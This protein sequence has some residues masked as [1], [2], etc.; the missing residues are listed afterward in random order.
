MTDREIVA[1]ITAAVHDPYR[2]LWLEQDDRAWQPVRR[3]LAHAVTAHSKA[4]DDLAADGPQSEYRRR[5]ARDVLKPLSLAL[6]RSELA[7]QLHDRLASTA[8]EVRTA[9]TDLPELVRAPVTPTALHGRAGLGAGSQ[10]KRIFARALRPVVWR[11]AEHDIAVSSVARVHLESEVIPAQARAFNASQRARAAWLGQL[12]RAW[13]SWMGGAAQMADAAGRLQSELQALLDGIAEASGRAEGDD[14]DRLAER[15]EATVAIAGTFVAND[16]GGVPGAWSGTQPARLWDEWAEQTA[17][18]LE[19]YHRLLGA[20]HGARSISQRMIEA[21][22]RTAREVDTVVQ[23]VQGELHAGLKR[24]PRLAGSAEASAGQAEGWGDAE[25]ELAAALRAEQARTGDGLM[26]SATAL[27]DPS[28]HARDLAAGAEEAVAGIEALCLQLPETLAVH[29]IPDPG[30]PIRRPGR[31]ARV[32]QVRE[33]A[34]QAFD[35][36]RMERI[37]TAPQTVVR[38]LE[39]VGAQVRELREVAAYAYEAAIAELTDA[40]DATDAEA[41]H[42]IALVTNGLARAGDKAARAR[43]GLERALAAAVKRARDEVEEGVAR[44]SHR[45]TADRLTAGYLDA[46]SFVATE[47]ARDWRRWQARLAQ[48][49]RRIADGVHT[50]GKLLRP[51][52]A[53]LGIRPPPAGTTDLSEHTLASATQF[54]NT[55]PVVYRRLFAF[56]PLTDP[57][58]LAGREDALAEV[59]ASWERWQHGGPGCQVVVSPPGAGITSFLNVVAG[60]MSDDAPG[61]V[62][63]ILRARIRTETKLAATLGTWLGL[64]EA[65]D[66]DALGK[67][68]L[69]APAAATP[70]AVVLEGAEHLHLRVRGGSRLFERLLGFMAETEGSV[71]WIVS[72]TS[73]AWQLVRKRAPG[74]VTDVKRLALSPLTAEQLRDAILARHLRSGL[75]LQY[76]E[77]THGRGALRTRA[78]R[79]QPGEKRQQLIERHYFERL[80]RASQGSIRLALFHWLRSADFHSREGS[81]VVQPL[82][83]LS[84]NMDMLDL[85]RSFALKA[86][87]DHGSLTVDEY[88]EVARAPAAEAPHTFRSLMD[89]HVIEILGAADGGPDGTPLQE[90]RYRVRPFMTGAV[91]AHLRSRNILH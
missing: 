40:T 63:K 11:R 44:L 56:E 89:Q 60:R 50:L 23:A 85:T 34:I 87:L 71:F 8:E 24:V 29:D 20:T 70:R 73:S 12:E 4:L 2:V 7:M 81:L 58:L 80:H 26:R 42:T 3:V 68:V 47:V 66:F 43:A 54:V 61:A 82:E 41:E 67:R 91:I 32:V 84:P 5:T 14:F 49:G 35:T 10:V 28:R 52:A 83:P 17:T 13:S 88:R 48:S 31:D 37:R 38:A 76:A 90:V 77:P 18:R 22:T 62:R 74:Y 65:D 21:W 57:K 19:L 75:P 1:A 30:E 86:I 79:I 16:R 9:L 6:R 45:V 36:L 72:L 51:L 15:L 27:D 64:G 59:T 39:E 33:A 78:R 53:A 25:E 46:R 55:L 69:Q